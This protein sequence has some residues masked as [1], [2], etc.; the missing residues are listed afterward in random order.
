MS[1]TLDFIFEDASAQAK[2]APTVT[3]TTNLRL[4]GGEFNEF[5]DSY[6]IWAAGQDIRERPAETRPVR[7]GLDLTNARMVITAAAFY[8]QPR[9][10]GDRAGEMQHQA[11]FNIAMP[12]SK[13]FFLDEAG[14]RRE[15][16]IY[17]TRNEADQL[18][19][20][21][22]TVRAF[23]L[24]LK[25]P[26]GVP[27]EPM[28]ELRDALKGFGFE[29]VVREPAA[30]ARRKWD[31]RFTAP[32]PTDAQNNRAV[33]Q[34]ALQENGFPITSVTILGARAVDLRQRPE[35]P[36]FE[37][38]IWSLA[39]NLRWAVA[40]SKQEVPTNQAWSLVTALTGIDHR[41]PLPDRPM[42]NAL[43]A[44]ASELIFR[45]VPTDKEVREALGMQEHIAVEDKHRKAADLPSESH[46][47][48]LFGTQ[49]DTTS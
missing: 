13:L 11:E 48:A 12:G 32:V 26:F 42:G 16:Y 49:T 21:P 15:H 34:R 36:E 33:R 4:V 10:T 24:Y 17:T 43:R 30:D 35:D 2:D 19:Y 9:A 20:L 1:N 28:T 44:T 40:L 7:A 37:G 27:V 41:N 46:T 45:D 38:F 25:S 14:Q 29:P 31:W 6:P 8:S 18:A 3:T 5:N 23:E 22:A 47:L 39:D